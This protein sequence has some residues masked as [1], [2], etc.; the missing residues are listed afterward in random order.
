MFTV[1]YK[2]MTRLEI[3]LLEASPVISMENHIYD[4]PAGTIPALGLRNELF[5][6]ERSLEGERHSTPHRAGGLH[7]VDGLTILTDHGDV[8]LGEQIAHVDD[9]F[10]VRW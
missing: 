1:I 6:K 3:H 8:T 10:H 7:Q 9:G 4:M 5:A 2:N